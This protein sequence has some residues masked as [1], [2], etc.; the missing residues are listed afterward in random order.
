MISQTYRPTSKH[1]IELICEQILY[2]VTQNRLTMLLMVYNK[3]CSI[4]TSANYTHFSNTIPSYAKY[5]GKANQDLLQVLLS[6][7]ISTVATL[8]T[9]MKRDPHT[10]RLLNINNKTIIAQI[11]FVPESTC[12]LFHQSR[13]AI[14]YLFNWWNNALATCWMNP[15]SYTHLDVYKRQIM[16]CAVL[17]RIYKRKRQP[18]HL[19]NKIK[20]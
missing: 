18:T 9:S 4:H 12:I 11:I 1:S 8:S 7:P 10:I 13:I 2:F 20:M 16:Q 3:L 6:L 19:L 5:C 15:V 14:L 17:V